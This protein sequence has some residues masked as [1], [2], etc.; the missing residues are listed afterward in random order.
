MRA[1]RAARVSRHCRSIAVAEAGA[2]VVRASS[3]T[4]STGWRCGARVGQECPTHR[5]VCDPRG[6]EG[7]A[8][9]ASTRTCRTGE[10][11][12]PGG[13]G[14]TRGS[15]LQAR[16]WLGGG[17]MAIT[18]Y[19][20]LVSTDLG[21]D[22]DDIQSLYRLLHYSDILR[23]EGLVSS[24]GPGA[25]NLE[26]LIRHWVTRVDLDHLRGKGHEELMAEEEVLSVI[27]QGHTE[28]VAPGEG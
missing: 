2:R 19:R 24:P 15:P 12:P 4:R 20:V 9:P 11:D 5:G 16:Y 3:A 25:K 28:P 10:S 26:E 14:R 13:G 6:N 1:W 17:T 18:T 23:I 21:G 22:P 8:C 27:R 7:G